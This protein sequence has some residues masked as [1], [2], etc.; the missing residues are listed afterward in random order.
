MTLIIDV[1]SRIA[2]FLARIT[3]K[4]EINAIVLTMISSSSS[5]SSICE[6]HS[7]YA[8]LLRECIVYLLVV[9]LQS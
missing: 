2:A 5:S 4:S 8:Y 7:I 3:L 1:S 9:K 6:S